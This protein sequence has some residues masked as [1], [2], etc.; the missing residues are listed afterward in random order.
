MNRFVVII[1]FLFSISC[2]S[3][4]SSYQ[5]IV[6]SLASSEIFNLENYSNVLILPGLG[7]DGC[8]SDVENFIIERHNYLSS[9]LII[10]TRIESV[11]LL[12][13]RLGKELLNKKY[14][15]IDENSLF[16]TPEL[17]TIY[18][19]RLILNEDG[20]VL[21]VIEKTP[22]THDFFSALKK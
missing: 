19:V 11:K 17:Q 13:L 21:E 8:I 2:S 20:H 3:R 5:K 15:I 18:P 22:E 9:T 4:V 16:D 14:V 10:L 12:R 7:C 6:N 1:F